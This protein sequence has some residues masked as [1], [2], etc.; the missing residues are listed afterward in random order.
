LQFDAL[1]VEVDGADLEI[2]SDGCDEG[3]GEAI[4]AEAEEAARFAHPGV[5]N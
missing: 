3:G 5:A 2:D 4:F 1:A